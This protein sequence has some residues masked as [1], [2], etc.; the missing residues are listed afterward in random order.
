MAIKDTGF[1]AAS[2]KN[3]ANLQVIDSS[4]LSGHISHAYLFGGSSIDLLAELALTFASSINCKNNG[5][6]KCLTCQ[7]TFRGI[8]ENMIIIEPEGTI[9]TIDKIVELQKFMQR[10]SY[11]EGKKICV[12][13]EA[14]LMNKEAANRLLKTIEEPPDE[15]CVFILLSENTAEILPTIS[16]RCIVFEWD[17][18]PK[19]N[20]DLSFDQAALKKLLDEAIKDIIKYPRSYEISLGLSIQIS[21]FFKKYLPDF[22]SSIKEQVKKHKNAGFLPADIKKL[23][24]KL[25]AKTRRQNSKFFNLGMNMVF[26]II[27]AWLGDIISV[28]L[29]A[30]AG[31]INYP[32]NHDFIARYYK[33]I[34]MAKAMELIETV[35]RNRAYLKYSIF[36]ELALD[37]IFLQTQSLATAD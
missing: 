13:K 7:N 3:K 19:D 24:E 22:E 34:N 21:G 36:E 16:S 12:I 10:S 31:S 30:G 4:L 28:S 6:G 37:N 27:T 18:E 25:K 32:E 14:D 11:S 33:K 23:E 9:L 15:N 35:E 29:G 17:F 2:K 8:H 1:L 5:C 26:D 20:I